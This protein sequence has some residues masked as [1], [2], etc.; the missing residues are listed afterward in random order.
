QVRLLT[1]SGLALPTEDSPYLVWLRRCWPW[2]QEQIGETGGWL[3]SPVAAAP[4]PAT[5]ETATPDEQTVAPAPAEVVD[6][7]AEWWP[8]GIYALPLKRRDGA[9]LGW[10]AFLLEQEPEP[11]YRQAL[12]HLGVHWSYC[13]E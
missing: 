12:S 13:W 3:A 9:V 10:A 6:G 4:A 1:L 2:I 8:E 11:L 7:W 5:A